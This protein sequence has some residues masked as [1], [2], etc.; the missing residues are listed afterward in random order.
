MP[1]KNQPGSVG[2][3]ANLT[4]PELEQSKAEVINTFASQNSRSEAFS[5]RHPDEISQPRVHQPVV[6][7]DWFSGRRYNLCDCSCAGVCANAFRPTNPVRTSLCSW[8]SMTVRT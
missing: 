1:R 3:S 2:L 7:C 6:L 8:P 4:I 5:G